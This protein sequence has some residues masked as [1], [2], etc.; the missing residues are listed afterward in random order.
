MTEL[1]STKLYIPRP[2]SGLV[3]RPRLTDRLNAGLD[4]KLTLISAPAGFGK[5]T[6]LSEWIPQSPRCVTWLSLDEGDNAPTRFWTYMIASVQ[7]IHPDLGFGALTRLQSPQAPPITAILTALI[8]DIAAFPDTFITVLDDYHVIDSQSIHE[9][10]AFLVDHMPENYHLVITTRVDPPLPLARLRARDQLAEFRANDLRFT[11]D[12]TAAFLTGAMGLS[13]SAEETAA[14]ETRTEG[15]IAGLQIAALSMQGR[16]DIPGFIQAFSGSHRHILGFLAEEVLNQRPKGTLDFLLQTSIL[17]RLCGPLCDAVTGDSG[18]QAILEKLELANLFI[19]P[20]DDEGVWYRYHHLFSEVLQARLQ[21]NQPDQVPELHRR[22]GIWFA[23]HGM[24][25]EAVHHALAGDD[26]EEAAR[27]IEA[28]AGDML[29]RGSSVSLIRWLDAIPEE[30]IRARPRLCLARAWTFHWGPALSLESADEWAQLALQAALANRSLDS[31]L[32]GEVAAVRALT[33]AARTEWA[34][35]REFSSQALDDLPLDSPWRSVIALCLGTAHLD[36]GNMTAAAHVLGEALSLS[37]AEGAH[38][39]QLAAASF[40]ADLQLFQGHLGQAMELYWQILAWAHPG[41]PQKGGVMAH[42][43]LAHILCEQNQ[44]GAAL[45]HVQLGIDQLDQVGGA[46]AA[47]LLYRVLA[48]VQQA[49]GNW[50]DGLDALDRAYQIGESTQISLVGTQAAALRACLQLAQGDLG[51]AEVWAANSGLSPDDPVASHP[52]WREV[53]YLSLARVLSAQGRY[54][55]ALSLLDLLMQ[56]AQ[57]EERHGSAIAIFASQALVNQA[58]RNRARALQCLERA[59]ALAEPEGYVRTFL[60]EGEPMRLLIHDLRAAITRRAPADLR[61]LAYID[62]LLQAFA[63]AD[64][65]PP[66]YASSGQ[67]PSNGRL[68]DS[69]SERELEVLRLIQ[70]GYNNQEIAEQLVIAVSTVKTHLNNL[71]GKFGV[72]SRTQ[73]VAIARDLGFLS[74]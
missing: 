25:E 7:Q 67:Q 26:Y 41:L 56:S 55:E 9:A 63:G 54:A 74:D 2:W 23:N 21:Q 19:T 69:L 62:R 73:A 8:N 31:D 20:L 40:L 6:L 3:S 66:P 38:Y 70:A 28:V 47:H 50:K 14:L 30:T 71:Y 72:H 68:V 16:D 60:D 57:A 5:T 29:R 18:G 15:W 39:I 36:S 43:G 1:L 42:A 53:E 52:G 17:D 58:Q 34:R 44:L 49:K 12:E 51:A 64:L 22:A 46:W 32:T 61:L 65:A 10:L 11:A 37:R 13:L 35:C 59:L 48:R 24:I 45:T 33:A 4:R 27:L